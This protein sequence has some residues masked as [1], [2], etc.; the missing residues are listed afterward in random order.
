MA[1]GILGVAA[2]AA[3]TNT[4]VYTV[5]VGKIATATLNICNL[6]DSISTLRIALADST[7]PEQNT[8]IEYDVTLEPRAVYERTGIVLNENKIIVVKSSN[9]SVTAVTYGFEESAS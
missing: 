9:T 6:G 8:F 3:T 7:T 1:T 2:L 4:A 5:P